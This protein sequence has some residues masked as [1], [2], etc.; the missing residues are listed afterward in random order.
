MTLDGINFMEKTKINLEF[1][2][3]TKKA[4]IFPVRQ[5]TTKILTK[6]FKWNFGN[7]KSM[8]GGVEH[9]EREIIEYGGKLSCSNKIE[10]LNDIYV[11]A[12]EPV[13]ITI[14]LKKNNVLMKKEKY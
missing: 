4:G 7:E 6:G 12:T 2:E 14:E 13:L 5:R 10:S 9:P 11:D 3:N 8:V 1:I